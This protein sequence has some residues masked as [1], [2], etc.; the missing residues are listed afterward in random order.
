[1]NPAA[2][3]LDRIRGIIIVDHGSRRA[4]SNEMLHRF[5]DDF[6]V[7]SPYP[8][9]E[10]AHMELASPS[11][12]DAFDA[13]VGRGAEEIVV[14]PYFLSPGR[15]FRQDIPALATEAAQRHPGVSF[16]VTAPIGLHPLMQAIIADRISTCSSHATGVGPSCSMCEGTNTCR[17]RTA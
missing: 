6:R 8:I 13:C 5:V 14:A 15:H 7:T 12:G 1:M 17:F 11:I 9:V 16:L 10:P 2:G 4:E 3:H